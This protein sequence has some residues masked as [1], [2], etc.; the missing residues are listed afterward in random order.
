M[1][2]VFVAIRVVVEGP[3]QR[4]SE[5]Q[6]AAAWGAGRQ[7]RASQSFCRLQGIGSVWGAISRHVSVP[8]RSGGCPGAHRSRRHGRSGL[9]CARKFVPW[10]GWGPHEIRRRLHRCPQR[11]LRR[12]HQNDPRHGLR[13]LPTEGRTYLLLSLN[14]ETRALTPNPQHP[15]LSQ[16]S[17]YEQRCE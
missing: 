8:G 11:P 12:K 17:G 13:P 14:I 3:Q 15:N 1:L 2:Q 9:G 10:A 6:L 4:S 16:G 5:K 7:G